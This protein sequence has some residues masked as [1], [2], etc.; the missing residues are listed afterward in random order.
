MHLPTMELSWT[1]LDVKWCLVSSFKTCFVLCRL[2]FSEAK[3]MV[4]SLWKAMDRS[5]SFM[6][7]SEHEPGT[8]CYKYGIFWILLIHFNDI[9]IDSS[10]HATCLRDSWL[11]K[12][13]GIHGKRLRQ[14]L[15][16]AMAISSL[17]T[18]FLAGKAWV[19]I[20]TSLFCTNLSCLQISINQS[21]RTWK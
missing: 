13:S 14:G 9:S 21:I 2:M 3:V 8:L 15:R 12:Q 5:T 6:P 16:I 17:S 7:Q 11:Q 1:F 10:T 18:P 4:P 20:M 19:R